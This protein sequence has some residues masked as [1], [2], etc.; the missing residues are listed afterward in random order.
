MTFSFRSIAGLSD[1]RPR[2]R[3]WR[4]RR[5]IDHRHSRLSALH[6]HHPHLAGFGGLHHGF[7]PNLVGD[8][9]EHGANLCWREFLWQFREQVAHASTLVLTPA[10]FF[11]G[12]L[13]EESHEARQGVRAT[14]PC[15][16][17]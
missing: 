10:R 11:F 15:A 8:G 7:R 2:V 1:R 3:R 6:D 12:N 14:G 17:N 4:V 5:R 16:C 13:G 9:A